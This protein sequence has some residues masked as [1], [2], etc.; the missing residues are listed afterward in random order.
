[1]PKTN[2]GFPDLRKMSDLAYRKNRAELYRF[3]AQKGI[4]FLKTY[5]VQGN[6]RVV[7]YYHKGA[8]G[9]SIAGSDDA[10]DWREN[11]LIRT[12][13]RVFRAYKGFAY[14]AEEIV[15]LLHN[16][17][18]EHNI[19][20]SKTPIE[21][22][23]HSRGGAIGNILHCLLKEMYPKT[24]TFTYGQPPSGGRRYRKATRHLSEN[25]YEFQIDGDPTPKCNP[26]GKHNGEV[27]ELPKQIS[28]F[29][30]RVKRMGKGDLNHRRYS[31]LDTMEPYKNW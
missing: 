24:I 19:N 15:D 31:V 9:I 1:M 6:D 29:W 7:I 28:G 5:V 12:L 8:V 13:K 25:L 20:I 30:N 21:G 23:H 26:F 11:V 3:A 22:S 16:F 2:I 17:C 18:S 14:P 27:I 4:K 10:G